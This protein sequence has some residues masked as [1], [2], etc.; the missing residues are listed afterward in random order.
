MEED[1]ELL[2]K[3]KKGDQHAFEL[4]V[5][6]YKTTVYNTIYSIIGNAQEADDIAQEVFLKVYTKAGSFKGKSSFSTWLYRITVNKCLDEL[7]KRN[8]KIISYETGFNEEEKLKLKDVLASREKDSTEELIQNELQDIIQ[9]AMN[10]L[11]EKY[12]IILTLKEIEGLSYNEISRVMKIS[13]GK[14]KIWLFRARQKLK[15][16]L[17]F[18]YPQGE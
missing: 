12:R 18:L 5:R 11:P 9:K 10:S 7:R 3:F 8:N 4:L 13:L 6:K 14:V 16:K 1:F 17:A 15:E 2:T